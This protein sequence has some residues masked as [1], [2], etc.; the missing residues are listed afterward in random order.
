MKD[1]KKRYRKNPKDIEIITRLALSYRKSNYYDNAN[2]L[3]LRC[4]KLDPSNFIAYYNLG[5]IYLGRGDLKRSKLCFKKTYEID[6][7]QLYFMFNHE[8]M[9][10]MTHSLIS[11]M[12]LFQS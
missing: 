9:P 3:F 11:E 4:L 6:S 5:E 12:R 2:N 8:S 1:L 10:V 7:E